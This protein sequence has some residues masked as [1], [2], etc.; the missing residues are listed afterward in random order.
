MSWSPGHV[1]LS[2]VTSTEPFLPLSVPS[3]PGR[4]GLAV[5]SAP[6]KWSAPCVTTLRTSSPVPIAGSPGAQC[7]TAQPPR[8]GLLLRGPG[9]RRGA[10]SSQRSRSSVL[11]LV[12]SRISCLHPRVPRATWGSHWRGSALCPLQPPAKKPWAPP[13]PLLPSAGEELDPSVA[14]RL[15][16]DRGSYR[17]LGQSCP[18]WNG[19]FLGPVTC[20]L[21]SRAPHP[22]LHIGSRGCTCPSE[23]V[24]WR[25]GSQVLS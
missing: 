25:L 24:T 15:G 9:R 19:P 4:V 2:S 1:K 8:P 12:W 3:I 23:S 21:Q 11:L 14:T 16:S 17:G 5:C 22:I 10:H 7:P 20:G 13:S 18:P 6:A